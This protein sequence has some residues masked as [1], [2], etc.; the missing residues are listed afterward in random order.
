MTLREIVAAETASAEEL[1]PITQ[2]LKKDD[3]SH[4]AGREEN[5]GL[6]RQ[7]AVTFHP[8]T[9]MTGTFSAL[10]RKAGAA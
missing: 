10:H 2:C 7:F 4:T 8:L 5:A 9:S 6:G 1:P 3:S